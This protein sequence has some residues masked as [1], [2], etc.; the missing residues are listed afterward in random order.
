MKE[1]PSASKLKDGIDNVVVALDKKDAVFSVGEKM[2][3]HVVV[4]CNE[5]TAVRGV[6]IKFLGR[7]T[8]HWREVTIH[9]RL[10]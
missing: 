6:K 9:N 7:M 4:F 8:L 2:T 5:T 1:D 3:G 10:Q